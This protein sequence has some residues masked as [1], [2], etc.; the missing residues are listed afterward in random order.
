M[1]SWALTNEVSYCLRFVVTSRALSSVVD[2]HVVQVLV[3]PYVPSD[4]LEG[5][6]VLNFGIDKRFVECFNGVF[7]LVSQHSVC[8]SMSISGPF[9][10]AK[11][12]YL[13]VYKS[14][15]NM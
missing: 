7:V 13:V 14:F 12:M 6:F 11:E 2:I 15:N 9:N 3:K 4:K 5:S 8:V 10:L 1:R